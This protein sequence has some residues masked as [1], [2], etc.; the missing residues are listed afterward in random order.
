MCVCCSTHGLEE[1]CEGHA[2]SKTR[3]E[4]N[5]LL[6]YLKHALI[7]DLQKYSNRKYFRISHL[8]QRE[9]SFLPQILLHWSPMQQNPSWKKKTKCLSLVPGNVVCKIKC[10][11]FV[12][13]RKA[14]GMF[15]SILSLCHFRN[16]CL[17]HLSLSQ[18]N[19]RG[20]C[21]YVRNYNKVWGV[22]S[23]N[24]LIC[25]W[26]GFQWIKHLWIWSTTVLW[27]WKSEREKGKKGE[28][29]RRGEEYPLARS[30]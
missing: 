20:S 27:A 28:R 26:I 14:C 25:S 29:R 1:R 6:Q 10:A 16:H 15:S 30:P 11:K 17:C 23:I 24:D 9:T 12:S 13:A 2:E 18:F 21:L 19:S 4:G 22:F 8:R 5:S 7:S 3:A